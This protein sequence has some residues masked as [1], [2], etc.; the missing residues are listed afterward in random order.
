M[1]LNEDLGFENKEFVTGCVVVGEY[2][3]S[4]CRRLRL[5]I[6]FVPGTDYFEANDFIEQG[7]RDTLEQNSNCQP[8]IYPKFNYNRQKFLETVLRRRSARRFQ[9]E[10]IADFIEICQDILQSIPT[11]SY[12][13]IEI[14]YIVNRVEE[15]EAGIY[16]N[17]ELIKAGDFSQKAGYLCVN[18]GIARDGAVTLFL[19]SAYQNYQTALQLAGLIGQRMYL[20]SNYR[21]ISC[22]GI[23]AYYDEETKEFLGTDKDILYGM[24]IGIS[25]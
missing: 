9:R 19:V 7:Y 8:I 4:N 17:S 10:S 5:K 15:M 1:A 11:E 13:D 6:P 22:S 2:E 12:E 16:R 23:G 21:G 18:Q 14:Y 25:V 3:E 20:A 24:V